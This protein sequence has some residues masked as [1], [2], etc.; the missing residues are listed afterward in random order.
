MNITNIEVGK[1]F[2]DNAGDWVLTAP[3]GTKTETRNDD[4]NVEIEIVATN[5][6]IHD[7]GPNDRDDYRITFR[8]ALA[9]GLEERIRLYSQNG[10]NYTFKKVE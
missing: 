9:H 10:N 8:T 4:N 7:S 3:N 2:G 5:A 1:Q 6:Q